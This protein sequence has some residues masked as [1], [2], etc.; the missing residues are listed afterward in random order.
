MHLCQ[1]LGN[2]YRRGCLPYAPFQV[3]KADYGQYTAWDL[4]RMTHQEAPW[5]VA[6]EGL[7]PDDEGHAEIPQEIMRRF[8]RKL[9]H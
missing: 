2:R 9:A 8:Y 1:Y 3:D 5:K 6:R 4:E 7:E